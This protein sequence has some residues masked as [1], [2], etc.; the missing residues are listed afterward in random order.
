MGAGRPEYCRH[1]VSYS[2]SKVPLTLVGPIAADAIANR[3]TFIRAYYNSEG[4]LAGF[5]KLVYGEVELTHRYDYHGNGVVK[6]ATVFMADDDPVV[7]VFDETGAQ[8]RLPSG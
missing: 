2:C 3:N 4:L 8:V 7:M 5:Q 1:F 6:R